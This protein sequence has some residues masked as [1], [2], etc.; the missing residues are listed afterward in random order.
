MIAANLARLILPAIRWAEDT[1]FDHAENAIAEA[2]ELG[3]GGF[4][5]FG[6]PADR[7]RALTASLRER[8]GRPLLIGADLE[9]GA[10]QQFAGLTELPPPLALAS[11]E[12][13]AAVRDAGALTAREALSVGVNWVF[14]PVADLDLL[15][16]NPIV[17]TRSFGSDPDAVAE[18]VSAWIDGCQS[19]GALAC[20]KHYPGHGRTSTDSH[21]GLPVVDADAA[22]LAAVDAVPFRAAIASGVAAVMTAHVAY[23]ALDAESR[24]ATRSH[25]IIAGLRDGLHFDG[26]VVTDALIMDG[27]FAG[28]TEGG[29]YVEALVAGVDLLL[30]PRSLRGALDAILAAVE[31]GVLSEHRVAE[32][33][34]R[35]DRM[36]ASIA[37]A[38]R[39]APAA[40]IPG[41]ADRL[42]ARAIVRGS[43]P[44]L[45]EPIELVVVDDDVGGPYPA[46]P[47]DWVA[48]WLDANGVRRGPGG[49]RVILAFA[50]PR[51]WKGRGGF[52]SDARDRLTEEASA[53]ALVVLFAHPRLAGE[54]PGSAPVLLAW[55]R[56]R[57]MQ[58][59]VARW[60][61]AR[62]DLPR[63]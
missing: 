43:P 52:G 57:P 4:I 44:L 31:S 11:L 54:L 19:E 17:Q 36:L 61:K 59:A 38:G 22:A 55:H 60:V 42:L 14:A 32:A 12:D 34:A 26:A 3:V 18:C 23:P 16:A 20:V 62:L 49:S 40:T 58:A 56:Q 33:L 28:R 50:E 2:L 9:R 6:G 15:A 51:A 46:S 27:A 21:A 30:Y 53:A 10:G 35:R 24:P 7:V 47:S 25:P 39:R 41:L 45:R 48:R 13:V 63:S 8:A 1:G 37:P 5:L 29:A